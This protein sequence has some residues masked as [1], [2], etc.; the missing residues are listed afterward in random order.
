MENVPNAIPL[1]SIIAV[2]AATNAG[3]TAIVS[4][5]K[6]HKQIGLSG[7][8]YAIGQSSYHPDCW[9]APHDAMLWLIANG[10]IR[11]ENL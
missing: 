9:T 3:P 4:C 8:R 10:H 5:V 1:E 2:P 11:M 7:G 6:C